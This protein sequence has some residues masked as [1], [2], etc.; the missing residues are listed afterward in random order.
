VD[1]PCSR[2][3]RATTKSGTQAAEKR[4]NRVFPG[5][6]HITIGGEIFAEGGADDLPAE[7]TA[8]IPV[9]PPDNC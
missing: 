1:M 6:R 7:A 5:A 3:P 2:K 8:V 4:A 9:G